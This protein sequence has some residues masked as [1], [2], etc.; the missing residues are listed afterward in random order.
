MNL[1]YLTD[2][3]QK[4][5]DAAAAGEVVVCANKTVTALIRRGIVSH[6]VS[7]EP[8]VKGQKHRYVLAL[9]DAAVARFSAEPAAEPAAETEIDDVDAIVSEAVDIV[10]QLID[11][12]DSRNEVDVDAEHMLSVIDNAIWALRRA[13]LMRKHAAAAAD[14]ARR[15]D[16][17]YG[18]A[19]VELEK[20]VTIRDSAE[21]AYDLS[22]E[23]CSGGDSDL[24]N[25]LTAAGDAY[26]VAYENERDAYAMRAEVYSEFAKCFEDTVAADEDAAYAML[27]VIEFVS[28][29]TANPSTFKG[30]VRG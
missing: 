29:H 22:C 15:A 26:I 2:S 21:L 23:D 12:A 18:I 3:Q 27:S 5:I 20:A 13:S 4:A 17:V 6:I 19:E 25:E 14:R 24:R 28:G 1:S 9:T 7:A 11:S 8:A 30:A 10:T 16:V